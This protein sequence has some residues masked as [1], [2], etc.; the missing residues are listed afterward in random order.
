MKPVLFHGSATGMQQALK[1]V[2][3]HHHHKF[4]DGTARF[5]PS[6][7]FFVRLVCCSV[8]GRSA[9]ETLFFVEE[10]QLSTPPSWEKPQRIHN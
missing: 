7:R 4:D 5:T 3:C 9:G 10:P 6:S 2:Q 8:Q 1:V